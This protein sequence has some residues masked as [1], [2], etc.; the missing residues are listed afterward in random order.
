MVKLAR[1]IHPW[2]T[3][4]VLLAFCAVAYL[5]SVRE[6]LLIANSF[7]MVVSGTVAFVYLPKAIRAM[8]EGR[9]Q[10]IQHITYGI[11]L[12]WG[13]TFLWRL[14][15]MIWLLTDQDPIWT[16]NDVLS[17]LYV[18]AALGA[19]Y[20]LTSPNA[21]ARGFWTRVAA[22]AGVVTVAAII[23]AVIIMAPPDLSWLSAHVK[24]LIPR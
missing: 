12:G 4:V 18:G 6:T 21:M 16:N 15:I 11:V 10:T 24:P 9:D 5:F 1:S 22:C 8:R 20:H 14:L 7:L 23:A 2:V 13:D 19:F 3:L 17:G